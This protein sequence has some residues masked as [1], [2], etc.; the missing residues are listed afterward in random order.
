[1]FTP[2][3]APQGLPGG[4]GADEEAENR[5]Q[6]EKFPHEGLQHAREVRGERLEEGGFREQAGED[7]WRRDF[8]MN[9]SHPRVEEKRNLP[10]VASPLLF[11]AKG[12]EK[13]PPTRDAAVSAGPLGPAG[14][15]EDQHLPTNPEEPRSPSPTVRETSSVRRDAWSSIST[16]ALKSKMGIWVEVGLSAIFHSNWETHPERLQEPR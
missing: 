6:P 15:G 11:T 16:S 13:T 12:D 8:K 14:H 7:P 3:P 9:K 1:M 2:N 4:E 10:T 5:N